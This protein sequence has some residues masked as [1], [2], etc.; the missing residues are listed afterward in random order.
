MAETLRKQ[1]EEMLAELRASTV[2]PPPAPAPIPAPAPVPTIAATPAIVTT[3]AAT[4]KPSAT[5]VATREPRD[6]A[7][8]P[9]TKSMTA[10]T[11]CRSLV[12]LGTHT[13]TCS[14]DL[15]SIGGYSV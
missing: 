7:K 12:A 11:D 2:P 14:L 15:T 13:Y 5:A 8:P 1:F 10:N 3:T 4:T 9:K 6:P